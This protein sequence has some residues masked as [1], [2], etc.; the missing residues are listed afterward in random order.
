MRSLI[1]LDRS[2]FR[3]NQSCGTP[4]SMFPPRLLFLRV[5]AWCV[6][7]MSTIP[8]NDRPVFYTANI[9]LLPGRVSISLWKPLHENFIVCRLHDFPTSP[10]RCRSS[11]T[12]LGRPFDRNRVWKKKKRTRTTTAT[13][14]SPTVSLMPL[15]D[16]LREC[17][18]KASLFFPPS[19]ILDG[20]FFEATSFYRERIGI[21]ENHWRRKGDIQYL[22]SGEKGKETVD[23]WYVFI[24]FLAFNLQKKVCVVITSLKGEFPASSFFFTLRTQVDVFVYDHV[25]SNLLLSNY[26]SLI[27]ALVRTVSS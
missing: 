6:Q 17:D 5:M 16:E 4:Y 27:P 1:I 20:V 12:F 14:Q 9:F 23:F 22:T 2:Q 11:E 10:R 8:H 21:D 18:T 3:G 19:G 7:R 25:G 24:F 26:S 15:G 13:T